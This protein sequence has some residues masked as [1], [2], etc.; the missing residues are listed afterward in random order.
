MIEAYVFLGV[1]AVQIVAI[2]VINS[3]RFIKYVR[4]WARDFGS[5]RF[6]QLYPDTDYQRAI[7]KFAMGFRTANLAVAA[8]GVLLLVWLFKGVQQPGWNDWGID[9]VWKYFLLQIS[10][11]ILLSLY[12]VVRLKALKLPL[13][14][15]E[16]AG[17]G[18]RTAILQRRSLFDFI[19]PA[20]VVLSL[21][22]YLLFVAVAFYLDRY[23]FH[24]AS[25]SMACLTSIV[26]V[27]AAY[28][29]NAIGIYK[30]LYG[31]NS[32]LIRHD[33]RMFRIG[34]SVRMGVHFSTAVAWLLM[35]FGIVSLPALHDWRPAVASAFFTIFGLIIHLESTAP[36][37][38]P[39]A[40][41]A[42]SGSEVMP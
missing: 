13:N 35:V 24:N 1:L 14:L 23:E 25:P 5:A 12:A 3:H 41:G 34:T 26:A 28:A 2:S 15:H 10:P 7:E 42:P 29:M 20:Q 27:T 30:G 11:A 31:A 38:K 36:P 21:A 40:N 4:G 16:Q 37:R 8:A 32:P 9:V 39:E 6:A 17:E 22:S 18:K 19:S 33:S